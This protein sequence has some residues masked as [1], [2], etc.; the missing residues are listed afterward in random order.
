MVLFN[1]WL[2][3]LIYGKSDEVAVV[4]FGTG[5]IPFYQVVFQFDLVPFISL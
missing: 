3:Q 5:G 4:V 1:L 2:L